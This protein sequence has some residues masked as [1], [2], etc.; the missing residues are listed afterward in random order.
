LSRLSHSREKCPFSLCPMEAG[1]RFSNMLD[2]LVFVALDSHSQNVK[3][4]ATIA[5]FIHTCIH[6]FLH[7]FILLGKMFRKKNPSW[8]QWKHCSEC[9]S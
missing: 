6:I 4:F 3:M 9:L 7:V 8:W 1:H 2:R 5:C